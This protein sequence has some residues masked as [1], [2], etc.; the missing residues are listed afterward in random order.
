MDADARSPRTAASF[1]DADRLGRATTPPGCASTT[2]AAVPHGASSRRSSSRCPRATR[3]GACSRPVPGAWEALAERPLGETLGRALRPR[4]RARRDLDRRADRDV[5]A[6]RRAVA[7]PERLLP[8]A[9]DRRARGG[10]RSAAWGRSPSALARAAAH[11][12]AEL[13]TGA[14]VVHR[15][16]AARSRGARTAASTPWTRATCCAASRRRAGARCAAAAPPA[17]PKGADE[18][19]HAAR[20]AAAAALG[21][22]PGGGVRRHVPPERAR[23]RPGRRLRGGAPPARCPTK[24]PAELYC[25]SLTDRSILGPARRAGAADAHAVRPAH[26]RAALPRRQRRRPRDDGRALPRL[27]RRAPRRADPRLPGARCGRRPCLEAKTPLDVERELGMPERQHLPRRH[28]VPVDRAPRPAAGAWRPTTRACSC[29][30][31]ARCAAG[32]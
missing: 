12:G 23:G 13:R 26:A 18:A 24:P 30:A 15:R 4:P 3:S 1:R 27:A 16:T 14:E 19:Q 10:C 5:R 20:P 7:A 25:H 21:R 2:P 28:G 11:A 32:A 6:R 8:V 9:R 31:R 22:A 17:P 29:A